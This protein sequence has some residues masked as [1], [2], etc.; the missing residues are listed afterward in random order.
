VETKL[1]VYLKTK[2]KDVPELEIHKLNCENKNQVTD[3]QHGE[4]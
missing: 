1:V 3:K 2:T 4:N